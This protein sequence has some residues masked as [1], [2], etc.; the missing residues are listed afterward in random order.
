MAE[1]DGAAQ[2]FK[3]VKISF[4][5][6][7]ASFN[8]YADKLKETEGVWRSKMNMWKSMSGGIGQM[9]SSVSKLRSSTKGWAGELENVARNLTTIGG[10]WNNLQRLMKSGSTALYKTGGS[11]VAGEEVGALAVAAGTAT[12][13]LGVAGLAVTGLA[14]AAVAAATGIYQLAQWG[15][16]KGRR[17]YGFGADVGSMSA[18]EIYMSRYVNPDA[19]MANAA[20]GRYDITSPQYVAMRAGLGMKGSFEGR[21][22]GALSREMVEAAARQMHQG[23]DRTALAV[24][25]ARGLGSLFSDEE[26]IRLR[27]SNEKQ[28]AEYV[29]E[30]E[31]RKSQ[32]ELTKEE[33]D[34]ENKL[35]TAINSLETTF[36]T[37]MVKLTA[38]WLPKIERVA[39]GL[40]NL[41]KAID[42]WKTA[43]SDWLH[44][45]AF[46]EDEGDGKGGGGKDD[47]TFGDPIGKAWDW[48]K[49]HVGD[50]SP[51]SSAH[52]GE[53]PQGT[54]GN[55]IIVQDKV[56]TDLINQQKLDAASDI[57]TAG[58][59]GLSGGTA[60]ASVGV[61][62]SGRGGGGGGNAE[63]IGPI[64][65]GD[66]EAKVGSYPDAMRIMQKAGLTFNEAAGLAGEFTA[67]TQ[68]GTMYGGKVL[69]VG[70]GDSG[71]A[72]GMAQ[73][74]S[75]RW[76]RQV[77]WAK[78][79]GLDPAK[80]STQYKMAAHEY[81]T[82]WRKRLGSRI[83]AATTAAGIE[84]ATEPFEGSAYGPGRGAAVSGT[85]RALREGKKDGTGPQSMND[86][87]GF[88]GAHPAH[89]VKLNVNNAAGAN[90]IVQGGMLGAGSG[91]FQV[92]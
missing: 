2:V 80:P 47:S 28:I 65:L 12:K 91:Q 76:N 45:P 82:E 17:A 41:I 9:E 71:A 3:E 88:Q 63:K 31:S 50:L 90:V 20:Q 43:I 92:A 24:A 6:F 64:D 48:L 32:Y 72:S 15:A 8:Q 49:K 70:T 78:S 11:M 4:D 79:Q 22:T 59:L 27:N 77:A 57:S 38:D 66:P 75:D 73:W 19:A 26:L 1:G 61:H 40:E 10:Q 55:P 7:A 53:L 37:E 83:N 68:L 34:A 44:A 69:G 18:S 29:K 56:L 5:E 86:L 87:S 54:A 33:I 16:G 35:I 13:A 23:S 39:A 67:E 58:V 30:A 85:A 46:P 51:V 36:M 52:A 14:T 60:R 89:F 25:H 21:E 81:I 62:T 84:A 74:H 42:G